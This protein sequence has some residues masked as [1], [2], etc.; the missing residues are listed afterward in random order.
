M[1]SVT[2]D[3]VVLASKIASAVFNFAVQMAPLVAQLFS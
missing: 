1:G 2:V 3:N